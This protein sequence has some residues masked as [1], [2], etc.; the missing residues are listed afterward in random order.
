MRDIEKGIENVLSLP[1]CQLRHA[2]PLVLL[3]LRQDRFYNVDQ[4][5]AFVK[6]AALGII[7]RLPLEPRAHFGI[8]ECFSVAL[9]EGP[10]SA[11]SRS[12][13]RQTLAR[14]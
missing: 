12:E 3:I 10:T 8:A 7:D 1:L 11:L 5:P 4:V 2:P 14:L 6:G 13:T 9:P